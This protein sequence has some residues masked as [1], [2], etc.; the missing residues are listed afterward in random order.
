MPVWDGAGHRNPCQSKA[1]WWQQSH[2]YDTCRMYHAQTRVEHLR[3]VLDRI[4]ATTAMQARPIARIDRS[5][6]VVARSSCWQRFP[7]SRSSIAEVVL[8]EIGAGITQLDLRPPFATLL[9]GSGALVA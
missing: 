6:P 2:V 9:L 4:D 8:A 3:A 7:A 1:P 5:I